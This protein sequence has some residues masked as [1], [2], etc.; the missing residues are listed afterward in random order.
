MCKYNFQAWHEFK[1]GMD[2]SK[3]PKKI[4]VLSDK[5]IAIESCYVQEDSK[6][7]FYFM[8]LDALEVCPTSNIITHW[9]PVAED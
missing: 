2:L 8:I 4:I 9:L 3:L 5:F 1:S 7:S 6:G